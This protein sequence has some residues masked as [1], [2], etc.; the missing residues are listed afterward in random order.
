MR[1]ARNVNVLLQEFSTT[2]HGHVAQSC[3]WAQL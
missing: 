1:M 2:K 3:V